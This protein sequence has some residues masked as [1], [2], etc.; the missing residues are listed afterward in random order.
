MTENLN[1]NNETLH[2]N[3]IENSDL[4]NKHTFETQFIN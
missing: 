4:P 2:K 1:Y 3:E